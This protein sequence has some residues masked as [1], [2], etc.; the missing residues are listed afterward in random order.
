MDNNDAKI[1]LNKDNDQNKTTNNHNYIHKNT[2]I[3][4]NK[5]S[6][7]RYFHSVNMDKDEVHQRRDQQGY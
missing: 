5:D 7:S 4:F 6:R 2:H 1:K 3:I